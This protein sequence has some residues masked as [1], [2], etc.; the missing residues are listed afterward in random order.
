M[1][2][3]N[4]YTYFCIVL[5]IRIR[6]YYNNI[7]V[8]HIMVYDAWY[9]NIDSYDSSVIPVYYYVL[10]VYSIRLEMKRLTTYI[11]TELYTV[12]RNRNF[13]TYSVFIV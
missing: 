9:A 11:I 12:L 10:C 4:R 13:M 8:V 5:V 7:L 6:L 1:K 3:Y 2:T